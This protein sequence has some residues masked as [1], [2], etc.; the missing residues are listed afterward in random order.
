M[1]HKSTTGLH[2]PDKIE[3]VK[4]GKIY[5][6]IEARTEQRATFYTVKNDRGQYKEMTDKQL[7]E[8]FKTQTNG[9]KKTKS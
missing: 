7:Y 9:T 2:Y 4:D 5:K 1:I 3:Q 6:I 8:F